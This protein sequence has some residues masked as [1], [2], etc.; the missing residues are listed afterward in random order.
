MDSGK[1]FKEDCDIVPRLDKSLSYMQ[2]GGYNDLPNSIPDLIE[3]DEMLSTCQICYGSGLR[4]NVESGT[5]DAHY[6]TSAERS[7]AKGVSGSAP[8]IMPR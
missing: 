1:L 7:V 4:Y 3:S 5:K 8:N 6:A 2:W